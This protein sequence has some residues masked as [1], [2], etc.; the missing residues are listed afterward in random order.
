LTEVEIHDKYTQ[1]TPVSIYS[2]T[3]DKPELIF[4]DALITNNSYPVQHF[5]V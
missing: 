4:L 5:T 1:T 2:P 3:Q